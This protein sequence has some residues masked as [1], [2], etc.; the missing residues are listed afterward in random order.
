MD[1]LSDANNRVGK[2]TIEGGRANLRY[3][4]R[5]SHPPE[6]VWNA[7]TDPK[8]VS[9]WF[10]TTAKIDARPGG[11]LEYISVPVGFRRTGRI[12]AWNP[13]RIFEHEWHI[14][15]HPQFPNGET[16]SVIRWELVEDAGHTRLTLT[17]TRLAMANG[18]RFAPAWHAFLDRLAAQL[19][20]E[21]PLP[22]L[23]ERIAAVKGL[24]PAQ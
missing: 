24:Y 1:I 4:R 22:D 3:E 13:P 18:L 2:V 11:D 6:V 10:S 7:I 15:P 12:L 5:F 9:A 23:A 14:D 19:D 16:E 21:E 20:R 17:H 8:Q